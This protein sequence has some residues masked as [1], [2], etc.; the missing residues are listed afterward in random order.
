MAKIDR[1]EYLSNDL[2]KK[3]PYKI[4]SPRISRVPFRFASQE[5]A[6]KIFNKITEGGIWAILTFNCPSKL[7]CKILKT[8][9]QTIYSLSE[10]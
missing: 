9:P 10:E 7:T 6:L 5:E 3:T 1:F 2:D 4:V 8:G